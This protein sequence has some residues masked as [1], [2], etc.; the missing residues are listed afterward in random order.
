MSVAVGWAQTRTSVG[1]PRKAHLILVPPPDP[2]SARR[3]GLTQ[4]GRLLRTLFVFT[5]LVVGV[6]HVVDPAPS[7]PD[8]TVDHVTTVGPGQSLTDLALRELPTVDMDEGIRR[9]RILNGLQGT[10]LYPGQPLQ[11]P[12]NR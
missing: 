4:R 1:A 7:S 2:A 6:L 12:V 5:L 10:G 11:I 9:I 8:L 3:P